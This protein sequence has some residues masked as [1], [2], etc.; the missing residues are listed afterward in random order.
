M[1]LEWDRFYAEMREVCL[2]IA[3]NLYVLLLPSRCCQTW[4]RKSLSCLLLEVSQ[5]PGEEASLK[6]DLILHFSSLCYCQH[7]LCRMEFCFDLTQSLFKI[8]LLNSWI[9]QENISGHFNRVWSN[10]Q[11][12]I[13]PISNTLQFFKKSFTNMLTGF[14]C[15]LLH[16][17]KF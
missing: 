2:P 6:L 11:L 3:G 10:H 5:Y 7:Q 17:K 4:L 1:K 15:F 12:R 16:Q 9:G 14:S 13:F 8:I